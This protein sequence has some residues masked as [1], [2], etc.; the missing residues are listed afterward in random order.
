[1]CDPQAPDFI[2][3]HRKEIDEAIKIYRAGIQL[4]D[5]QVELL[6]NAFPDYVMPWEQARLCNDKVFRW[7]MRSHP[8]LCDATVNRICSRL[9]FKYREL[10]SAFSHQEDKTLTLGAGHR[11]VRCDIFIAAHQDDKPD[12]AAGRYIDLEH[13][14]RNE[15]DVMQ[16][17]LTINCLMFGSSLPENSNRT[18][19][20]GVM[21][22]F[23]CN[24]KPPKEVNSWYRVAT[25]NSDL[26]GRE[27][28][29]DFTAAIIYTKG[30]G[31]PEELSELLDLLRTGDEKSGEDQFVNG[32]K[33]A[34]LLNHNDLNN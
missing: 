13:Q 33:K 29:L 9:P 26:A 12:G 30:Q 28:G 5:D 27:T 31:I 11:S 6:S 16:R 34:Q 32:I 23:I 4:S 15:H 7:F 19:I 21:T 1:M 14:N 8:D 3:V 22:I 18:D 24:F 25:M 10:R 20:P 2:S 17:A